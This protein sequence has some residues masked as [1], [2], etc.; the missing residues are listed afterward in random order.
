MYIVVKPADYTNM[1]NRHNQTDKF[2]DGI[3]ITRLLCH[4]DKFMPF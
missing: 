4:V 2:G 1:I 3:T